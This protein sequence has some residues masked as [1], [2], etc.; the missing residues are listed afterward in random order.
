MQYLKTLAL[1]F[2]LGLVI[3]VPAA[4]AAECTDIDEVGLRQCIYAPGEHIFTADTFEEF[5]TDLD[6]ELR[7]ESE[8]RV[9]PNAAELPLGT[10][11]YVYSNRSR[12]VIAT[13]GYRPD[14]PVELFILSTV[15][16]GEDA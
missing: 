6:L 2:V 15:L 16:S 9:V 14:G 7:V 13:L 3:F 1:G 10:R 11:I 4:F 12:G 8:T 5:L